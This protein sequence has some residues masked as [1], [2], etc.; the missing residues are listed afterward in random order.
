MALLTTGTPCLWQLLHNAGNVA[1][2]HTK[3]ANET[4]RI[5]EPLDAVIRPLSA[6]RS[7]KL[8]MK[9]AAVKRPADIEGGTVLINRPSMHDMGADREVNDKTF[10]GPAKR[11]VQRN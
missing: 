5:I 8:V 9:A 7:K 4:F 3:A 6:S 11:L 10:N 1:V 2:A